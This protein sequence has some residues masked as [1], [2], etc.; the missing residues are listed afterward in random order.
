MKQLLL[1]SATVVLVGW[2]NKHGPWPSNAEI[3]NWPIL[4]AQTYNTKI[5]PKSLSSR[6]PVFL[7]FQNNLNFDAEAIWFDFKGNTKSYGI[8]KA[9][10]NWIIETYSTHPWQIVDTNTKEIVGFYVTPKH[11]A[12]IILGG[13]TGEEMKATGN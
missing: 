10:E 5:S 11:S 4:E 3:S 8:V 13:K 6:N 1:T 9:G 2:G 12:M 7:L